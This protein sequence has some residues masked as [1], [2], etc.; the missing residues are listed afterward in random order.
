MQSKTIWQSR[1]FWLNLASFTVAALAE[2]GQMFPSIQDAAPFVMA[3]ALLNL[4]L[5]LTTK[6]P[7][8]IGGQS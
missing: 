7:I 1:T 4:I 5:R 2:A 8:T 6:V 3:T